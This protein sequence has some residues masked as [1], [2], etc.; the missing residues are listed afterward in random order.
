MSGGSSVVERDGT[1]YNFERSGDSAYNFHYDL[2]FDEKTIHKNEIKNITRTVWQE[3][4]P[5]HLLQNSGMYLIAYEM[6]D[7]ESG[8][9]NATG[10]LNFMVVKKQ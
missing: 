2:I 3:V 8:F 4:I 6:I 10:V 1:L 9:V 5:E 7:T